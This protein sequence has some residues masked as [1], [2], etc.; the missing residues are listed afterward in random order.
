[1][2]RAAPPDVIP[3]MAPPTDAD[4]LAE[5]VAAA[6]LEHPSVARLHGGPFND[7]ATYLAS[8]RLVGVRIG[9]PGEPVEVAVVLRL[10][11]PIPDVVAALR[12]AVSALCPG[13]PVDVTVADIAT[14]DDDGVG[15]GPS[16]PSGAGVA[17][18]PDAPGAGR[19]AR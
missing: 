16:H 7:V 9:A 17:S 8:G 2:T 10:D 4:A 1:V 5:R 14:G 6:V 18:P 11:R 19:M 15:P 3:D 13:R 12:A